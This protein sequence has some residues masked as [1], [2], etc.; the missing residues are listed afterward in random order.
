MVRIGKLIEKGRRFLSA[1]S[2]DKCTTIAGTLVFFLIM[3]L[4]PLSFWATILFA[5][6]GLD[7]EEILDLDLFEWAK[8]LLVFFHG[9]AAEAASGAGV[10]FL[11][12]TLWSSTGFFY[13]MRRSG[14]IVY[15][16][17][18]K[19]H[20]WRVRLSAIALTLL[21]LLFLA[22]AVGVLVGAITLTRGFPPPLPQISVYTLMLVLGFFAAWILNGYI[23]PYRVSPSETLAG[24]ALTAG[25]WLVASVA[26]SVY[27]AL[28][29]KEKL[30]GALTLFVVFL[31]WLYWMMIC[32]TAGAIVNSRRLR[33]HDAVGKKY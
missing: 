32:F 15:G 17:R 28:S 24:S 26:F 11:L 20:G 25:A 29:N 1:L 12:A 2:E 10:F 4:M 27:V 31:L 6:L 19:K 23:C 9:N 16:Y 8:E 14:E 7:A 5:R 22:A 30:Y 13:H 21:V 3:S 18:R 33:K